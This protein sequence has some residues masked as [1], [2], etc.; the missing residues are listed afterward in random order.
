MHVPCE[1]VVL[2]LPTTWNMH[3]ADVIKVQALTGNHRR[4]RN[5]P[6]RPCRM[7]YGRIRKTNRGAKNQPTPQRRLRQKQSQ[8]I[9]TA[10]CR[11]HKR[12]IS[13]VSLVTRKITSHFGYEV[14][15]RI[16]SS[17]LLI[18][19]KSLYYEAQKSCDSSAGL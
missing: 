15:G 2:I 10:P 13:C 4:N 8:A 1:H 5:I 18:S 11:S 12:G 9:M 6:T 3:A 19:D 17:F 7:A 16:C 14:N